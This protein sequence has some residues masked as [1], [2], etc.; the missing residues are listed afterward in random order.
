MSLENTFIEDLEKSCRSIITIG[1]PDSGKTYLALKYIVHCLNNNTYEEYHLVLP[2]Y[3]AE[4]NNSYGFLKQF[5]DIVRIYDEYDPIIIEGIQKIRKTKRILFMCDDAT[6]S[7]DINKDRSLL[8]LMST[9]RHAKGCTVWLICHASKKVISKPIR[10]CAK[11]IFI[12]SIESLEVL[13]K[14]IYADYISMIY[15]KMGQKFDDFLSD[16]TNIMDSNE[17]G[18]ILISRRT[19]GDSTEGREVKLDLNVNTWSIYNEEIKMVA[20]KPVQKSHPLLQTV[21]RDRVHEY[22]HYLNSR[23]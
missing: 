15:K 17:Y 5:K 3:K 20:K 11:Y 4:Y 2:Q 10:S 14:D 6:G 8:K 21:T 1:S 16:Y 23:R 9:T 18:I 7:L 19:K 12:T 22:Q 13:E